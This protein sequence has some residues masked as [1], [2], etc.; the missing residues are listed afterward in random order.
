MDIPSHKLFKGAMDS[1][2]HDWFRE[3]IVQQQTRTGKT[4]YIQYATWKD[5]KQ[6]IFLHTA[7]GDTSKGCTVECS[8]K[9][10]S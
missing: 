3:A 5:K 10:S 4:Y 1:I 8:T 9:G 7:K 6:V 2:M